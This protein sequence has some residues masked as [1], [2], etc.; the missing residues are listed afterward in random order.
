M[1]LKS[2]V[3]QYEFTVAFKGFE[4]DASLTSGFGVL[5]NAIDCNDWIIAFPKDM[6]N[7][8]KSYVKMYLDNYQGDY[9]DAENIEINEPEIEQIVEMYNL[10]SW[11][12]KIVYMAAFFSFIKISEIEMASQMVVKFNSEEELFSEFS[13]SSDEIKKAL[14]IASQVI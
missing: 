7:Q 12:E 1:A 4:F 14:V 2:R 8:D 13:N 11:Q 9:A 3:S 10:E 6:H 5:N